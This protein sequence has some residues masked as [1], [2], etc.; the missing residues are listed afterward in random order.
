MEPDIRELLELESQ[1]LHDDGAVEAALIGVPAPRSADVLLAK[2]CSLGV[3]PSDLVIDLGCGHGQ[4][5]QQIA[6]AI[7]CKVVALDQS[8]A[9]VV[10][11]RTATGNAAVARVHV[12]RAIAEALPLGH[13]SVG[14]VWCRDMLNHVDLPRTL[15]E[16]AAVLTPGGYMLVY[17][18]FAT[19]LLE[20]LEAERMYAAFAIV[21]RNMDPDYFEACAL[22]AGFTI[23]E[24]DVIGSEWRE[25]W[26]VEGGSRNTS[27]NLI[28]AARLL[29]G[30]EAVKKRLGEKT[31]AFAMADQLWG[32]YQMIGK[33]CPTVYVLRR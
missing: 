21:A 19:K 5:S 13:Q 32:V 12:A 26:E 2:F 24:R 33:L 14:F 9:R 16:C 1:E 20:P 18:T 31:Y 22:D 11:T 15:R 7:G 8:L 23:I 10:E 4:Y 27:E 6:S 3:T 29:R 28:R 17:Q 25:S 30:S